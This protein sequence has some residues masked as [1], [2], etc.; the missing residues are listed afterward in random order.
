MLDFISLPF[1]Y[2]F[3]GLASIWWLWVFYL[4]V[5]RLQQ[6]RDA[7]K[8]TAIGRAVGMTVLYPGY[9]LDIFVNIVPLTV[10]LMEPPKWGEWTVTA[11]LKRHIQGEGW[12]KRLAQWM[13]DHFLDAYDPSGKHL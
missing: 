7:G 9:A 8:M 12:R 2:A 13:G 4:A 1:V 11:R 10:I 6:V 3:K 5:M